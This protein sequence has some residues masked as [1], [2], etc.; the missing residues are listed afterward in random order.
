MEGD[1]ITRNFTDPSYQKL[2]D[3]QKDLLYT[4][5]PS[6]IVECNTH[7]DVQKS[8]SFAAK[9]NIEISVISTGHDYA[10]R[11]SANDSLQINLS[12][13]KDY[14]INDTAS[15]ITV[16]TR[17]LLGEI[18]DI[19]NTTYGINKVFIAGDDATVRPAVGP[20]TINTI[21]WIKQ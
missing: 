7:S 13:F 9:Y 21:L 8:V 6:L 20:F 11:N 15:T 17:L 18:Y 4:Q 19:V 10:S 3:L 14:S 16:E 2:I 1:L 12:G 5:Y